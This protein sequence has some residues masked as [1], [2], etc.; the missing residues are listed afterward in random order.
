MRTMQITPTHLKFS[1]QLH[2]FFLNSIWSVFSLHWVYSTLS[3]SHSV[4]GVVHL[5]MRHCLRQ[6]QS[7]CALKN[8]KR[9]VE[10]YKIEHDKTVGSPLILSS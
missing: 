9:R 3:T 5:I 4:L 1:L 2:P 8:E 7:W 6:L 10:E